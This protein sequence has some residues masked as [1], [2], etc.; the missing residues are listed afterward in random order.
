V[1]DLNNQ[2]STTPNT[3]SVTDLNN[4]T[5]PNEGFPQAG[6]DALLAGGVTK[7]N[8]PTTANSLGLDVE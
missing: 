4:S 6:L 2:T 3:S 5:T 7:A 8:K 1:V